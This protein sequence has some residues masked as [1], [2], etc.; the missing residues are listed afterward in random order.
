MLYD[1]V[2]F[3]SVQLAYKSRYTAWTTVKLVL[4]NLEWATAVKFAYFLYF[5][6]ISM[7]ILYTNSFVFNLN[8]NMNMLPICP[9]FSWTLHFTASI[10][11]I[12]W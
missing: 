4:S 8:S 7:Y 5:Y 10:W 1:P 11:T 9:L 6:G 2:F 12:I 3:T